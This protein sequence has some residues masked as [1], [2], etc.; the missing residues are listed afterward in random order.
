MRRAISARLATPISR[1]CGHDPCTVELTQ[2]AERPG[3]LS[4][5]RP[6]FSAGPGLF[7]KSTVENRRVDRLRKAEIEQKAV[8]LNAAL[9]RQGGAR[10]RGESVVVATAASHPATRPFNELML[11]FLAYLELERGLS[12]NTLEAYRSDLMQFGAFLER[13]GVGAL[14]GAAP[15]PQQVRDPAG[16]R[17]ARPAARGAGDRPAQGRVPALV[18]PS[19]APGGGDRARPDRRPARAQAF[20]APAARADPGRGAEAAGRSRG[21]RAR[22][23]ARPRAAGGDVRVRAARLGGGRP[24]RDRRRPGRGRPARPRKGI[25]GAARAGRPPGG[26]RA[27]GVSGPRPPE[28][29]GRPGRDASVRQ[30]PRGAASRARACTRSSSATPARPAW[31]TG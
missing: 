13:E 6:R 11:D 10:A 31:P 4:L 25:E 30:P 17:R 1:S 7:V 29:R 23:A 18:L 8:R 27:A 24:R 26:R 12:R 2:R 15:P 9:Q 16:Q 5:H 28:A 20:A 19:P 3:L 21:H 22:G 14:D